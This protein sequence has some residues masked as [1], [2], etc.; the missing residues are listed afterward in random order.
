MAIE[1]LMDPYQKLLAEMEVA[2]RSFEGGMKR[3]IALD[4]GARGKI[5]RLPEQDINHAILLKL[6]AMLSAL[7]AAHILMRRGHVMEQAAIERIADEAGEDVL[8]LTLGALK[9]TTDLHKRFLD[10]FW[11]EEFEDFDD[12]IGSHKSRE[13]IPRQKIRA[14]I[15]SFHPND[16][17]TVNQA[18]KV[19]AKT[20]SGFVHMAA[21]HIM[22]VYRPDAEIFSVNGMLGTPRS[23]EHFY[24]FWNYL[25][26]GAM[27][28]VAAAKAFGS[29]DQSQMMMSHIN[30]FQKATGRE[31]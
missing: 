25:Y 18:A 27:A 4:A 26:R 12:V 16:P 23:S 5:Q 7:N 13:M 29:E 19:I 6:V 21:P 15:H 1:N 30:E 28:F 8:F 11:A 24:D 22:E 10:A 14:Y 2:L 3:P 31:F 17:S 20:Y 9:G